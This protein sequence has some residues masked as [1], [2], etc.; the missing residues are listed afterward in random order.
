MSAF[1]PPQYACLRDDYDVVHLIHF[2]HHE[3]KPDAAGSVQ[4]TDCI[5]SLTTLIV[6][7]IQ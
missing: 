3:N 4:G 5:F 2:F 6:L 7:L 1:Y